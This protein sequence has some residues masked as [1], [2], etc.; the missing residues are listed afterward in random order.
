MYLEVII[1][2]WTIQSNKIED[3]VPQPPTVDTGGNN[4]YPTSPSYYSKVNS[5]GEWR[6]LQSQI[7]STKVMTMD[8]EGEVN[9]LYSTF[10]YLNTT[11]FFFVGSCA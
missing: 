4:K 11:L 8:I 10:F 6:V 7:E 3:T 9:F 2:S 5:S 1:T